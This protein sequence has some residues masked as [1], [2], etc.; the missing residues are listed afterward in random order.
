MVDEVAWGIGCGDP[1]DDA[2][3]PSEMLPPMR[4]RSRSRPTSI[5][6]HA[7]ADDDGLPSPVME[8]GPSRSRSGR[9]RSRLPGF[10]PY[11]HDQHFPAQYH[12]PSEPSLS[13]MPSSILRSMSMSSSGSTCSTLESP[14]S[15]PPSSSNDRGRASKV[16]FE[17]GLLSDS[18][19]RSPSGAPLSP[20]DVATVLATRG[21]KTSRNAAPPSPHEAHQLVQLPGDESPRSAESQLA[22]WVSPPGADDVRRV[23]RSASR[24][25]WA[26]TRPARRRQSVDEGEKCRAESVPPHSLCSLPWSTQSFQTG[27]TRTAAGT[28]GSVHGKAPGLRSQSVS[29]P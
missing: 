2:P 29:R 19:S 10:H 18:R 5:P 21:R 28:P 1:D 8:R 26:R 15:A 11:Q 17:R 22:L 27:R 4:S 3:C 25:A 7:I 20:I 9:S 16:S 24:D 13:A 6:E 23:T 14:R 12:E